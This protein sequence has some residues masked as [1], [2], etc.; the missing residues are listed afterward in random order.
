M[1][2]S[3][4]TVFANDRLRTNL[5][6]AVTAFRLSD[7]ERGEWQVRPA[8]VLAGDAPLGRAVT[9]Q[10]KSH[11]ANVAGCLQS[12]PVVGEDGCN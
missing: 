2:P 9:H 3:A 1:T 8:G 4:G 5:D 10:D 7:P 12:F 11:P 6:A